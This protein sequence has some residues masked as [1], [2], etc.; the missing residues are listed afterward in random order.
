MRSAEERVKGQA[1][2][3]RRQFTGLA[4][5]AG[6]AAALPAS[7]KGVFKEKEKAWADSPAER[8][9]YV[10]VCHGC[11]QSC[12]CRVYVE[13]GVVVKLEGHPLAPTS[14]GS[15]CIK[16][17]NQIHTCYSP[18]RILYPLK[19]VGARGAENAEWERI[20]WDEAIELASD[21]IAE[22]IEKYGTYSFFT[23]VGG[24]GQY[25]D[26]Q[27][28]SLNLAL[29]SP[30]V[31]EPGCAQCWLP[32]WTMAYL[33]YGGD[34]QSMADCSVQEPFK[35]L[36]PA[37]AAKG[38]TND[39]KMLVLWGTQPSVS[40]TAQAGRGMAELRARGLKTVVVD[41]NMSPDAVKADV[42]L[43]PR[44]ATDTAL[45]MSWLRYIF[46]NDLYDHDFTKYFTNL[47]VLVNPD[48]K[49][50]YS[51]TDLFPDFKQT[52]PEDTP[53]YVCFDALSGTV[54]P[55]EYGDPNVLKES[56]DP[57]VFW[58]GEV[59]GVTVRSAGKIYRDTVEPFTLE[60]AEELTDVPADLNERA[61]RLYVEQDVAGI[62]QG[63][64]AD[65]QQI[66]S[67]LPLALMGLDM[68]MGYVNKPGSTLTQTGGGK[69]DPP[70]DAPKGRATYYPTSF[71]GFMTQAYG[72]GYVLGMSEKQNE[73]RIAALPKLP[74]G[75]PE[76]PGSQGTLYMFQQMQMDRLG[77]GNHRGLMSWQFSH[78]PSLLEAIK[79]GVPYKPRVWYDMS[80]N[81]LAMLGN[82]TTWYEVLPEIDFIIGQHPMLTSFHMEAC[83]LVF[84][85]HEWLE[86]VNIGNVISNAYNQM[87]YTFGSLPVI[88]LGETVSNAVPP[89]KVCNA[90]SAKL[91]AYMEAGNEVVFG[92]VG[93]VAGQAS[94]ESTIS[95]TTEDTDREPQTTPNASVL[96]EN[97]K[98]QYTLHFPLGVGVQSGLEEDTVERENLAAFYA[99]QLDLPEGSLTFDELYDN[100][101][102]Y[103]EQMDALVGENKGWC[104]IDPN[105]YWVYDQHLATATD[106][107]PVGFGTESRKCEVYCTS[108]IKLSQTGFPY[109]YPRTM[110]PIDPSI[111]EEIKA[112]NP[113]YEYVG[114][115]SPICQYIE[116]AE[117]TRP[118]ASGYDEEYPL[119]L[120]SGRLPYFHHSTMRHA[121]FARELMPTSEVRMNQRTA[122]AHGL[123]HR[124]WVEI[125]SHRGTSHARVY[126]NNGM[127]D[128]VLW[129]ERYWN[130]ECYDKSQEHVT[131]GWQLCNVNTLTKNTAPFNEVF[132]SY[133]NRGITVNIKKCDQPEGIWTEAEEFAPFLPIN[134][135]RWTP[136]IGTTAGSG[137]TPIVAFGDW[138]RNAVAGNAQ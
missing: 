50:P 4:M 15:L 136:D 131:G 101:D 97:D 53:A 99:K 79:T 138:D 46:E 134:D 125:T 42:W 85:L 21:K 37:E 55:L 111:G 38:I 52:T 49:L 32:R 90:T 30:N 72:M 114:M 78:I 113:D 118:D 11:I 75:V 84:P 57:E 107:L 120:T 19:R 54:K 77:M 23:S 34:N 108:L 128:N 95:S 33:M 127:A 98:S 28:A 14:Q 137:Q 3:T 82:A 70:K 102:H 43:R 41:P 5:L 86:H 126:L 24:G 106:G 64:A 81:K 7:T 39:T 1:S 44:P 51:A 65:M 27:A 13:D 130:P 73:E 110:D 59:D 48:T 88:H 124:D 132:G 31:F 109:C 96:Y 61:I 112:Q 45:A 104:E 74:Q 68:V 66:A 36:A 67:Q 8:K 29:G 63:V 91:N 6:A 129:M 12:P 122:E 119:V 80:G 117:S 62:V 123:E 17:L 92:S 87:N 40:Q 16:G 18:L 10:T 2:L 9:M 20:S 135:N 26:N 116:P 100:Y 115:Y 121:A 105:D 25:S 35:G 60:R 56:I 83:D 94:G 103:R 89:Q 47:P 58:E 93:G 69:Y 22:A 71:G 133:T 76:F